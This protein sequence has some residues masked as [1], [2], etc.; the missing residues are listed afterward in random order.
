MAGVYGER[1]LKASPLRDRLNVSALEAELGPSLPY[2][3]NTGK[4]KKKKTA[5]KS[6]LASY[7]ASLLT[8]ARAAASSAAAGA[9]TAFAAANAKRNARA[10]DRYAA[11]NAYELGLMKGITMQDSLGLKD[12]GDDSTNE[13]HGGY[14]LDKTV[15]PQFNAGRAAALAAGREAEA[16][17]EETALATETYAKILARDGEADDFK[18]ER[19]AAKAKARAARKDRA[20]LRVGAGNDVV[21]HGYEANMARLEHEDELREIAARAARGKGQGGGPRFHGADEEQKRAHDGEG[22]GWSWG[23]GSLFKVTRAVAKVDPSLVAH[24]N[25]VAH[26]AQDAVYTD[27]HTRRAQADARGAAAAA[28][29]AGLSVEAQK[30][31]KQ[32]RAVKR[33]LSKQRRMAREARGNDS[34]SSDSATDSEDEDEAAAEARAKKVAVAPML[35]PVR[36]RAVIHNNCKACGQKII[37]KSRWYKSRASQSGVEYC[38]ECVSGLRVKSDRGAQKELHNM[39]HELKA[40]LRSEDVEAQAAAAASAAAAAEEADGAGGAHVG[41]Y[42]INPSN[43]TGN[44]AN[45]VGRSC[46]L[47]NTDDPG[48]SGKWQRVRGNRAL[49]LCAKC[50]DKAANTGWW[51]DDY[52]A[53]EVKRHSERMKQLAEVMP[54]S[55]SRFSNLPMRVRDKRTVR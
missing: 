23:A 18:R 54:R 13:Y 22:R 7:G 48:P 34:S 11:K 25:Q 9:T 20:R 5:R 35:P 46:T 2:I 43:P 4:R 29:E 49:R 28:Q 53:N 12:K 38:A 36:K 45:N 6:G 40:E 14:F 44:G 47:C 55:G 19:L 30:T 42:R 1:R 32:R 41:R 27:A 26:E 16:R 24:V 50:G 8:G 15:K 33:T 10:A 3:G 51:Q 17:K 52:R 39:R 21:Q 37:L 31:A